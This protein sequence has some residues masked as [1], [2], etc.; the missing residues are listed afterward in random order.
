MDSKQKDGVRRAA[1]ELRVHAA[2]EEIQEA[3]EL[4]G[5]AT[6]QVCS[7]VGMV[8]EWQRLGDLYDQVHAAWYL[9]RDKDSELRS[10]GGPLLDHEPT[11]RD[12]ESKAQ[13]RREVRS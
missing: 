5:R 10:S 11:A 1:A 7:I 9:V 13:E 4:L 3:Q 8:P 12:E 6:A 2:L